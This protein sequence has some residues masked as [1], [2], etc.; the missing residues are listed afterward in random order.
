V[1]SK[2]RIRR[3][4]CDGKVRHKDAA[5][6]KI[7]MRKTAHGAAAARTSGLNAYQCPHCQGWHIGHTR[8]SR[9]HVRTALFE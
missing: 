4:A 2:R 3:K 9:H 6:A 1:A 8:G 7:A 5:G